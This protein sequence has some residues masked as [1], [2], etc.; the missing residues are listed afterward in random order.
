MQFIN[1]QLINQVLFKMLVL[2]KK[3]TET[4]VTIRDASSTSDMFEDTKTQL[5]LQALVQVMIDE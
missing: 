1:H 2:S 3:T 5:Q 4:I